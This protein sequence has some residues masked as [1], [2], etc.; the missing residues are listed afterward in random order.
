MASEG[1][2]SPTVAANDTG[3]GTVAWSSAGNILASDDARANTANLISG[4]ISNYLTATGFGFAI[5]TG[6][7]IDGIVVEWERSGAASVIEDE[8]V[9]I[10]KGGVIGSTDRSSANVWGA[11]AYETYGGVADLWGETWTDDDINAAT[12][13]CAIAAQN[14]TGTNRQARIDHVRITV[15]YTEGGGGGEARVF[16]VMQPMGII[17]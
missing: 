17:F 6:A 13:G 8:A 15:H 7:T 11:E 9:R 4:D 2:L 14:N 5:P 12:F 3:I 1:P 16:G 10:I